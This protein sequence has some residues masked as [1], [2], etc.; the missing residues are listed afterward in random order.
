VLLDSPLTWLLL[1]LSIVG[2]ATVRREVVRNWGLLLLATAL[3]GWI[4]QLTDDWAG[5]V[6]I[7]PVHVAF[8]ILFSLGWMLLGYALWTSKNKAS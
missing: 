5:I 6:D 1:G 7:R 4:Y 2:L 8:G 3:F